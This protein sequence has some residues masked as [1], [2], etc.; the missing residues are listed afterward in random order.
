MMSSTSEFFIARIAFTNA[1]Q[2]FGNKTSSIREFKK[3]IRE[4]KETSF[5]FRFIPKARKISHQQR[6]HV[7]VATSSAAKEY[8]CRHSYK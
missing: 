7:L 1:G 5:K 8:L 2:Y 6:N 3:I 4:S